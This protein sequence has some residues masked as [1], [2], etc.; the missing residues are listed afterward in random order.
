MSQGNCE[1]DLESSLRKININE[2]YTTDAITVEY[3]TQAR[4]KEYPH[5][6]NVAL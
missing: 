2:K 1:T 4:A 5:M 3:R 6:V